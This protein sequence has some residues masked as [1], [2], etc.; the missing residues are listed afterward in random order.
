MNSS[1]KDLDSDDF[2]PL[3]FFVAEQPTNVDLAVKW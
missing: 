1:I 3:N 2:D